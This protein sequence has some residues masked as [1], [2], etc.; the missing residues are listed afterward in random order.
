MEVCLFLLNPVL[1]AYPTHSRFGYGMGGNDEQ[2]KQAIAIVCVNE[3]GRRAPPRAVPN[4][5]S[6][7]SRCE[8]AV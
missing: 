8:Q 7:T 3:L 5:N 6:F 2:H 1:P 4:Y